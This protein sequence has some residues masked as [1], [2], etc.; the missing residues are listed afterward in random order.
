MRY[1]SKRM[2]SAISLLKVL[3]LRSFVKFFLYH[4]S[5]SPFLWDW[6]LVKKIR[7]KFITEQPS[8]FAGWNSDALV[9]VVVPVNNA[10]S[11]GVERLVSSLK[12]QTHSNI[13]LIAVD[14]GSTDDTVQWLGQQGFKV[15]EIPASSFTHAYSRNTGATEARGDYILFTVDDA[16]FSNPDWLRT[17]LFLIE[18]FEADSLSSRQSIDEEA[19]VYSRV[20]NAFLSNAQSDIVGIN[21]SRSNWLS[22]RLRHILPLRTQQRSVSIDDT[23]HLVRKQ[24]F[25]RIK[26]HA[27]TVEDME[28]AIN[29]TKAGGR[30]LYTNLI[31]ILHYHSYEESS[32]VKYARRVFIDT[33][34]IS[35]WQPYV[36]SIRSREGFL[37]ASYIVLSEM[38]QALEN[39]K[40][41]PQQSVQK[42]FEVVLKEFNNFK[43]KSNFLKSSD[44][45]SAAKEGANLFEMVC[46][47]APP[48]NVYFDPNLKIYFSDRFVEDVAAAVNTPFAVNSGEDYK[49]QLRAIIVF[50]WVNRVMSHLA[51][52]EIFRCIERNYPFDTW[53]VVDWV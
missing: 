10:R 30:T 25:E 19:C 11:K 23:N 45:S 37:H 6:V 29:L 18:S 16:V 41:S 47:E 12:S 33:R 46:G 7:S 44:C 49:I 1:L 36:F 17:A 35:K 42:S 14:S 3:G 15:I 40:Y 5:T 50:L 27:P 8:K 20:L 51:R 22:V 21:V 48:S 43:R 28:F 2:R 26:F 24:T 52:P 13:E 38:L 34:V 53:T 32:L 31:S 9:S 39:L 4:V